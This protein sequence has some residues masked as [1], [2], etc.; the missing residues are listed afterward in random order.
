MIR[1]IKMLGLLTVAALAMSSM[2]ASAAQAEV[3]ITTG[4]TPETHTTTTVTGTQVTGGE[5]N[6]L[7]AAGVKLS[8][9]NG[10]VDYEGTVAGGTATSL[11]VSANYGGEP[12]TCGTSSN[13]ENKLATIE[14]HG[15]E[16][17]F[18]QPTFI[19]ANTYEGTTSLVCPEDKGPTVSI[20]TSATHKTKL[21][22]V[23]VEPTVNTNLS[24]VVYH[25]VAGPP[26]KVTMTVTAEGMRYVEEGPLCPQKAGTTKEDLKFFS[27]VTLESKNGEDDAWISG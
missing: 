24:H 8:C 18:N 15:C 19:E 25:N 5:Q 10:Q 12:A 2:I 9:P 14:M 22:S 16:F 3:Q 13:P 1:N 27:H 21:C 11:Q 26:D 20:Y 7:E 17:K 4:K 23:E 6:Y